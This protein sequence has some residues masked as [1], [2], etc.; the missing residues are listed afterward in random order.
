MI[1][2]TWYLFL[3]NLYSTTTFVHKRIQLSYFE[4]SNGLNFD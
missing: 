2:M 3:A 1:Y 4:E